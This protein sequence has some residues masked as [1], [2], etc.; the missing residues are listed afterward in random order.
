MGHHETR[1]PPV[2]LRS[3]FVVA[4]VVL[5]AVCILPFGIAVLFEAPEGMTI[6]PISRA[7]GAVA[8]L[9]APVVAFIVGMRRGV[10]LRVRFIVA[11]AIMSLSCVLVL[12][13]LSSTAELAQA[14]VTGA[15]AGAALY[16]ACSIKPPAERGAP[17]RPD[18]GSIP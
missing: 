11:A 13:G 6:E 7:A 16:A 2:P 17:S 1:L 10:R 9:V 18:I 12:I 8:I 15:I 4:L 5:V 14:A 3:G